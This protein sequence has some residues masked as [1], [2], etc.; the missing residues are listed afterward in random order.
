MENLGIILS[1]IGTALGLLVTAVTFIMKF[2]NSAK[3]K[4]GAENI[5]KIGN[6]VIPY[7]EQAEKFINYS[8]TEKKEFVMTKANQF[9]L[10][11][12]ICFDAK[13]VSERVEELVKLTK[14]VNARDKDKVTVTQSVPAQSTVVIGNTF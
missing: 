11:Q 5:I 6:A 14:Q 4:K 13:A 8:G 1:F 12:G 7:I 10:T 2:I 9:A 3:A